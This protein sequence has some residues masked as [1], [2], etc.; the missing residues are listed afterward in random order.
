MPGSVGWLLSVALVGVWRI[1]LR[2][3]WLLLR[4]PGVCAAGGGADVPT[5]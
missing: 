3:V 4:V 2:G 1:A 5:R